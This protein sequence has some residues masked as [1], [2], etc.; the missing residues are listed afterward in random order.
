LIP[1]INQN[2]HYFM[3]FFHHF[4]AWLYFFIRLFFH[5][6]ILELIQT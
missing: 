6:H 3:P 1:I 2:N 5:L 4:L